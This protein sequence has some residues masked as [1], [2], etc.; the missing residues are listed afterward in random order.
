MI[1]RTIPPI[2]AR[3]IRTTP[4]PTERRPQS[5]PGLRRLA[6]RGGGLGVSPDPSSAR[7]AER[8]AA[9]SRRSLPLR[10]EAGRPSAPGFE[11]LV[12]RREEGRFL[13]PPPPLPPL[14]RLAMTPASQS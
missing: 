4:T 1:S 8:S 7:A 5:S 13:A 14:D 3:P 6:R 12:R 9:A 11:P 10:D 2:S